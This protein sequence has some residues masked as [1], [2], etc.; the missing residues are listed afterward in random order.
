MALLVKALVWLVLLPFRLLFALVLVPIVIAK[1]VIGL[2][3]GVGAVGLLAVAGFLL[4]LVPLVPLLL[5]GWIVWALAS[6]A[7]PTGAV[8]AS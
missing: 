4:V 3:A 2:I 1:A 6:A 5:I 8:V 7:A